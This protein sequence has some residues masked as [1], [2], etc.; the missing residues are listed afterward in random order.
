[1][2]DFTL[3]TF[4]TWLLAYLL[5]SVSSAVWIGKILFRKDPRNAGSGNAGATNAFRVLG[6]WAGIAVL[7]LDI[8]KGWVAVALVL[9]IQP[10]L[11]FSSNLSF[12]QVLA[13][14]VAVTGHV[15]PIFTGFRGGKGIATLVGVLIYLYPL[16]FL[17]V[18]SV[19]LLVFLLTEYVSL[20]SIISGIAF[21]FI[22]I[23]VFQITEVPLIVLSIAI[24][25]FIPVTH[26]KNIQRLLRGQENRIRIRRK[27][28]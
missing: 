1:M 17:V 18:V 14:A 28:D 10:E 4:L 23:L 2:E 25:L 6:P 5:G 26:Q 27:G 22:V 24:A 7:L 15:F 11:A 9:W 3:L 21:P 16:P 12:L 8:L 20:G 13:G 19:F